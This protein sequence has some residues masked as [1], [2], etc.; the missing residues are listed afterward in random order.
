MHEK[1]VHYFLFIHQEV[2]DEF[3][4]KIRDVRD[5]ENTVSCKMYYLDCLW[6]SRGRLSQ[7]GFLS[8]E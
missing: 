7:V 8:F 2:V 5:N 6:K 1:I 3:L 4:D